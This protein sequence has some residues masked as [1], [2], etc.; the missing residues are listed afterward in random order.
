MT[1]HYHNYI[2]YILNGRCWNVAILMGYIM[3]FMGTK[4][5][6]SYADFTMNIGI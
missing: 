5:G 1:T 2:K 3:G 4:R 6:K